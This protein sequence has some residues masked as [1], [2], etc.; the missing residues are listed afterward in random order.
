MEA[1]GPLSA[2]QMPPGVAARQ[3]VGKQPAGPRLRLARFGLARGSW[4]GL[5]VAAALFQA[6]A[7]DG[8]H[9]SYPVSGTHLHL[10]TFQPWPG[11]LS[12]ALT[13]RA[14]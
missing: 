14:A 6:T 11:H 10:H 2:T 7:T 13:D 12:P 9:L 8:I 3:T 1:L 5:R 4:G